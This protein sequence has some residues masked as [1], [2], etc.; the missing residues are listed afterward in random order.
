MAASPSF[1]AI[2][3][4]VSNTSH[5]KRLIASKAAASNSTFPELASPCDSIPTGREIRWSS[6]SEV[7]GQKSEVRGQKSEVR[8]Q[9]SD[10]ECGYAAAQCGKAPPYRRLSTIL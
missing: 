6:R 7:G 9:R 5:R 2:T 8:S 1:T 4:P 10:H 3:S